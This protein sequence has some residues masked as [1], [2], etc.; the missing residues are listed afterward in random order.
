[1]LALSN[2][3]RYFLYRQPTAMRYGI[4]SLAG[5]V[6]NE[7]HF[8]PMNGEV[9]VFLGKRMNQIRLLQ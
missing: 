7:L 4:D 1:M 3:S 2:S 9:F 8:D 6:Q 5:L